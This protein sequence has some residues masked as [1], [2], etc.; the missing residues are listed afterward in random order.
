MVRILKR[1]W[2]IVLLGLGIVWL[3]KAM[4]KDGEFRLFYY[5]LAIMALSWF[6][7]RVEK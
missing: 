6:V 4:P 2:N 5:V 7:E 3:N 1:A